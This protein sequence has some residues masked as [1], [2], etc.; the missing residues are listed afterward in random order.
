M[1]NEI[2]NWLFWKLVYFFYGRIYKKD[3]DTNLYIAPSEFNFHPRTG[4][5]E[6]CSIMYY[7]ND[8]SGFRIYYLR[9]LIAYFRRWLGYEPL[10]WVKPMKRR[11][12]FMKDKK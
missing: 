7:Q 12:K 10:W 8:V 6:S 5:K 2:K 1:T 3:I 9:C 11:D 4:S